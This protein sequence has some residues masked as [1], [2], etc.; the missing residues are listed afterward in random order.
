VRRKVGKGRKRRKGSVKGNRTYREFLQ[1]NVYR[2]M[3]LQDVGSE[4]P[5]IC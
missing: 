4:M 5:D 3:A 2:P 1:F